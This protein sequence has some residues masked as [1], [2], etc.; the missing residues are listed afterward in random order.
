MPRSVT[1]TDGPLPIQPCSL[2]MRADASAPPRLPG[3]VRKSMRSTN[4][5][6]D[7]RITT[8]TRRALMAISHAPPEPGNRVFGWSYGA[9]DRG[10]DVAEPV[11]LGGAQEAHVDEAALEVER[12]QVEHAGHRRGTRD[13]GRVPDGQR[14]PGR[15]R[16]EDARFVDQLHVRRHGQL[17][18]V[19][20]DVG[21]ADAHEADPL[22]GQLARGGHDHHL[23][24]GE[25]RDGPS[26]VMSGPRTARWG[27]PILDEHLGDRP[28]PSRQV[29]S[30]RRPPAPCRAS[31][32]PRSAATRR[33]VTAGR[34]VAHATRIISGWVVSAVIQV[35]P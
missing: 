25:G 10:V 35:L 6:A 32:A 20:R 12:E 11:D 16:P 9:D 21:Q 30:G 17:G 3:E 24:A 2:R 7:W 31:A 19:D 34:T 29:R 5:R 26:A 18:Q 33:R 14:Q 8:N 28:G 15:P 23:R 4:E 22:A 27:S 13:D 1:T